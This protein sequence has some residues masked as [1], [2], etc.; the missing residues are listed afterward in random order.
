MS[1][2]SFLSRCLGTALVSCL[3][4]CRCTW[5]VQQKTK[6]STWYRDL[7]HHFGP[8]PNT[9]V[10]RIFLYLGIF[11]SSRA[12]H[13]LFSEGISL[14]QIW[15]RVLNYWEGTL[16]LVDIYCTPGII[17]SN[18]CHFTFHNT[19][20]IYACKNPS[21]TDEETDWAMKFLLRVNKWQCWDWNSRSDF[22]TRSWRASECQVKEFGILLEGNR[23][24]LTDQ[25]LDIWDMSTHREV[26]HQ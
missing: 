24:L 18:W 23:E 20:V 16:H 21:F 5:D 13:K 2:S 15:W 1:Q 4:L 7:T 3:M 11:T 10:F 25:Q 12:S 8:W 14:L 6:T 9:S 22:S 17:L 26:V 19:P